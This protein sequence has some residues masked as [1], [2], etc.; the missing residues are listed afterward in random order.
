VP[1]AVA[2]GDVAR[3][4]QALADG[5][6][7]TLGHWA[8]AVEQGAAAAAALLAE[9]G[10]AATPE[11]FAAVPSFWSDLHGARFRSVGLPS[12]A[13]EARVVEYDVRGRRLEISYHRAGRLVGALTVGRTGRLVPY[14]SA[15]ATAVLAASRRARPGR[16]SPG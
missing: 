4:P 8:D 9:L 16:A 11:P 2:A 15:L 13:D 5:A 3:V 1:G 7:M 10:Q 14:R 6:P 12:A